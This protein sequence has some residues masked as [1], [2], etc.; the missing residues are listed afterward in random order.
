MIEKLQS[1]MP[2]DTVSCKLLRYFIFIRRWDFYRFQEHLFCS[3]NG[4]IVVGNFA[5]T[6]DPGQC[7]HP[8]KCT[9]TTCASR[10]RN[11]LIKGDVYEIWTV[12]MWI[13]L[14]SVNKTRFNHLWDTDFNNFIGIVDWE[15][16]AHFL[17]ILK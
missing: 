17:M 9:W 14:C 10:K 13:M 11:L 1:C 7:G 5:P 2:Y 4:C 6:Y 8:G 15:L 16:T 12:W 3:V